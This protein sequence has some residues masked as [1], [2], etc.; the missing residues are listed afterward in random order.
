M[1]GATVGAESGA[2]AKIHLYRANATF[3]VLEATVGRVSSPAA[4]PAHVRAVDSCLVLHLACGLA[5]DTTQEATLTTKDSGSSSP[6]LTVLML[7]HRHNRRPGGSDA[8]PRWEALESRKGPTAAHTSLCSPPQRFLASPILAPKISLSSPP[9]TPPPAPPP[10]TRPS[11]CWK[12][13]RTLRGRCWRQAPSTSPPAASPRRFSGAA[14]GRC[15]RQAASAA[16]MPARRTAT[17]APAPAPL[18][19]LSA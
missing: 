16:A 5:P 13:E 11:G 18:S 6:P 19:H 17:S 12:G 1:Q 7:R 15:T 8:Q 14:A 10:P 2:A 3:T 9:S 4:R